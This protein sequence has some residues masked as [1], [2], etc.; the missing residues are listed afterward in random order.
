[1]PPSLIDHYLYG[2]AERVSVLARV[3]S[4]R[5]AIAKSGNEYT[6]VELADATADSVTLTAEYGDIW[7]LMHDLRAMGETNALAAR[8]RHPTRRKV[9]ETCPRIELPAK[10][11]EAYLLHRHCLHGVAP[12]PDKATAGPD[13]RPISYRLDSKALGRELNEDETLASAEVPADD[14]LMITADITAG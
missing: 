5:T 3:E 13:G 4:G 14:R 1:M 11:G 2:T 12:W 8:P 9:F 6:Q 10:P 7:H